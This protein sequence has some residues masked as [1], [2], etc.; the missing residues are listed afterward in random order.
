MPWTVAC[1]TSPVLEIYQARILVW[2]VI[3]FS[4]LSLLWCNYFA[5]SYYPF[6]PSSLPPILPS[7]SSLSCFFL[8][9]PFESE[10]WCLNL[11]KVSIPDTIISALSNEISQALETSNFIFLWTNFFVVL[12]KKSYFI[13]SHLSSSCIVQ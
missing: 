7:L 10:D 8:N 4:N 12:G 6:L 2:D 5:P 11:Q 3:A 1:Q 9:E 13:V